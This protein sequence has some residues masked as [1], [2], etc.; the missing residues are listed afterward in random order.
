MEGA[1]LGVSEGALEGILESIKL[2]TNEGSDEYN[3]LGR[4]E[5]DSEG[6]KEIPLLGLKDNI[7]DGVR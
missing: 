4:T 2:G 1:L 6:I 5:W 3:A 7:I